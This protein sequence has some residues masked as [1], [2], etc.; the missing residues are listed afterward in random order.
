[1]KETNNSLQHHVVQEANHA[2]EARETSPSRQN[3][4][5]RWNN[6]PLIPKELGA[7]KWEE[8]GPMFFSVVLLTWLAQMSHSYKHHV[9]HQMNFPCDGKADLLF[10]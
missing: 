4:D 3:L 9:Y 5:H 1:M 7:F 6:F 8:L 10:W 2:G